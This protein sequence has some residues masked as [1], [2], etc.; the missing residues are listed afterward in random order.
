M[1]VIFVKMHLIGGQMCSTDI[2][3]NSKHDLRMV[4]TYEQIGQKYDVF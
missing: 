4:R 2:N 3:Q 1:S